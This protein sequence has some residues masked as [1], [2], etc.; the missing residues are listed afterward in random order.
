MALDEGNHNV[1]MNGFGPQLLLLEVMLG[2]KG[3]T[4]D[5]ISNIAKSSSHSELMRYNEYLKVNSKLKDFKTRI[6]SFVTSK[7]T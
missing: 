2:A 6:G 7:L 4:Y 5:E 3:K 1:V